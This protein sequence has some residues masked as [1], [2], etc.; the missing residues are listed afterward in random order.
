MS[1]WTSA[2]KESEG[3]RAATNTGLSRATFA[4]SGY[5]GIDKFCYHHQEVYPFRAGLHSI[6]T[7]LPA[8]VALQTIVRQ[9]LQFPPTL[10]A[11]SPDEVSADVIYMSP[12]PPSLP[13]FPPVPLPQ[14]LPLTSPLSSAV[15]SP[16]PH[17]A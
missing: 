10:Q 1:P 17:N 8:C 12:L 11:V 2:L 5:N 4:L 7:S 15:F 13:L 3:T 14:Y 6:R 9:K 16:P